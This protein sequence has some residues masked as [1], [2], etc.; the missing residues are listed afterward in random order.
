MKAKNLRRLQKTMALLVCMQ[1]AAEEGADTDLGDALA[2]VVALVGESLRGPR[3]PGGR[4]M[5]TTL[6]SETKAYSRALSGR[7]TQ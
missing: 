2:I 1:A 7:I 3:S 6:K 4:D 5:T